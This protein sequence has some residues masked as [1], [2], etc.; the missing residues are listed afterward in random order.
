MKWRLDPFFSTSDISCAGES[1][2]SLKLKAI[3]L[4]CKVAGKLSKPLE[5]KIKRKERRLQGRLDT[6]PISAIRGE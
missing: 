5:P 1:Q 2:R 6:F 4:N 3:S